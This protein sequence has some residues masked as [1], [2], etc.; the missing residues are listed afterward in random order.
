MIE[1]AVERIL[2]EIPVNEVSE[3]RVSS[4]SDTLTFMRMRSYTRFRKGNSEEIDGAATT[5][6]GT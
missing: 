3:S 4:S 1:R 2:A 5:Q 6:R